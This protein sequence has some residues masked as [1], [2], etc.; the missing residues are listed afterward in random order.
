MLSDVIITVLQKRFTPLHIA[1][2][3]GN[4][5]VIRILLSKK[6]NASVKGK[7]GLTP[8]H[9]ATHYRMVEAARVLLESSASP[10]DAAKV[11]YIS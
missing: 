7:N 1:A 6:A 9:V 2:K 8:L 5:S 10:H 3:Y 11:S 4:A